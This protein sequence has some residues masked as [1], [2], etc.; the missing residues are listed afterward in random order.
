MRKPDKSPIPKA[1]GGSL[2]YL[3]KRE[4]SPKGTHPDSWLSKHYNSLTP[5]QQQLWDALN[6]GL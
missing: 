6:N 1:A 3:L 5:Y 2:T 4:H